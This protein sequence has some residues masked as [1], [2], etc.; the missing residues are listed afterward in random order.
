[1]EIGDRASPELFNPELI[2]DEKSIA[3]VIFLVVVV[4]NV[5]VTEEVVVEVSISLHF[6][7]VVTRRL[8]CFVQ[9]SN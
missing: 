4:E 8:H 5:V 3:S 2:S 6:L 1:L 7:G 9:S